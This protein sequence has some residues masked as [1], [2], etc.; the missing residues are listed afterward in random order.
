[1]MYSESDLIIPTLAYLAV[2][3]EGVTTSGLIA[4]LTHTLKPD[5]RDAEIIENRRDTFFSQ[6]VRNLV[7]HRTL[8]QKGLA[9]YERED[10][11]GLHKITEGG[12]KYLAEH[13]DGYDFII[14]N[15]FTEEQRREVIDKDYSGLVVEEGYVTSNHV[16][17]RQRSRKLTELARKHFAVDGKLFCDV[18]GFN[19]EDSYG[20][21]GAGFIEIHHLK[22]I[23]TYEENLESSLEEALGNVAPVCSNC[24]RMIHR[25]R[26]ETLPIQTLRDMIEAKK[27]KV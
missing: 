12:R 1:M 14:S 22:P 16:T 3:A 8:V 6:K 5:G 18:C 2:S 11:N 15:G 23:F 27:R 9:T 26:L 7:S 20:A 25:K 17:T 24:H 21:I 4:H 10:E 13:I 19:F